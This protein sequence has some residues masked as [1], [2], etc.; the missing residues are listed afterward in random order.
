MIPKQLEEMKRRNELAKDYEGRFEY[1]KGILNLTPQG[2]ISHFW[3]THRQKVASTLEAMIGT[4]SIVL[5][6]GVG[7]GDVIPLLSC[8]NAIFV[9]IDLNK[10]W[11]AQARKYCNCIVADGSRIPLKNESIDLVICNMALHHI[12]DQNGLESVIK[13]SFRC[14]KKDGVFLSFEPN[15][16]HPSGMLLNLINRFR[17]Y[18]SLFGGSN[19]ES[20]ISPLLLLKILKKIFPKAEMGNF[21]LSHPRLPIFIQKL[22]FNKLDSFFKSTRMISFT[23]ICKAIK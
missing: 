23:M 3:T 17:L 20:A 6:T 19:Y 13:E 12:V 8:K 7:K 21:T 9:G 14:L 10:M 4:N 22:I 18:H 1:G 16:F 5:F 15:S 2:W 11:I